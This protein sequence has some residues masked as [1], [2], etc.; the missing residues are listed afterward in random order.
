M[1][2]T[3]TKKN[4]D[5][6]A[7]AVNL[8]NPPEVEALLTNWHQEQQALN[9]VLIEIE[10]NV[11]QQLKVERDLT[12]TRLVI[13]VQAIKD[14][15]DSQGSYQNTEK[16]E[17]AL[18]QLKRTKLYSASV[19]EVCFPEYAQAVLT[20]SVNVPVLEGLIKGNLLSEEGLRRAH[21]IEDKESF[22]YI[23]K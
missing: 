9:E 2:E 15:I 21:I 17:Y 14:A 23:I 22:A 11:P 6:T 10:K 13:L 20:K 1:T 12:E 7:S 5:Y 16:G 4:P 18:R 8:V 3:K 19:F